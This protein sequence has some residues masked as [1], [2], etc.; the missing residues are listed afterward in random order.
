MQGSFPVVYPVVTLSTRY[1]QPLNYALKESFEVEGLKTIAESLPLT[2]CA[3]ALIDA[4]DRRTDFRSF[5]ASLKALRKYRSP[6]RHAAL[7]A[8]CVL[9]PEDVGF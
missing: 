6:R 8:E 4:S 1:F 5:S 7:F 9:I 3:W 2:S